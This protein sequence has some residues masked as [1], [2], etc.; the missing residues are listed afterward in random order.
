M[1]R[2]IYAGSVGTPEFLSKG[3]KKSGSVSGRGEGVYSLFLDDDYRLF[4]KGVVYNDNAGIIC[5]A[6]SGKYIY[7][8]NE[9]RDFGGINGSG[10]GVTAMRILEDGTLR[11]I[12]DSISYGSRPSYVAVSEDDRFLLV[13][14]HGSH[15]VATC[16]YVSDKE[17]KYVLSRGYDDSSI[18]CFA[19]KED[20]SIGELCDLMVFDGHGYWINGGGQSGSHLHSVRCHKGLVFCGNRGA[21]EIEVLRLQKDG[22]LSLLERFRTLPGM[23]PR[24]I[25]FHP[26]LDLIYVTHENY[27]CIG[28]Y[29]VDYENGRLSLAGVYPTM[30]EEYMEEHPI[31]RFEKDTCSQGEVNSSAMADFSRI[32]PSDIHVDRKG[33]FCF[34]ANRC[35]KKSGSIATFRMEEDGLLNFVGINILD[36][37]DPRGFNVFPDADLLAVGLLDKDFVDIYQYDDSGMFIKKLSSSP[38]PSCASFVIK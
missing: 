30:P 22:K 14:N 28:V 7:A 13:S 11:K 2:M 34:A 18:A 1:G 8:A 17:G 27:P 33:K 4:N 29:R 24:H 26:Y 16:H 9:S 20:G 36:G 38:V 6:N 15:S 31:P 3:K 5:I 35:L 19:L 25:D 37:A 32:M 21:D 12:N 23:A 10:G